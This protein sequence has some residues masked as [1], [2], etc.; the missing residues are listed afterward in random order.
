MWSNGFGARYLRTKQLS[1]EVAAAL[2]EMVPA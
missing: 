1:S 2:V